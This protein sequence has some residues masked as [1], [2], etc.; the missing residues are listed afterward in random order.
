MRDTYKK[1]IDSIK[2]NSNTNIVV[3]CSTSDISYDLICDLCE[4]S[5]KLYYTVKFNYINQLKNYIATV[6]QNE[7]AQYALTISQQYVNAYHSQ[8][9]SQLF[10]QSILFLK[11]PGELIVLNDDEEPS[12]ND[13]IVWP[14]FNTESLFQK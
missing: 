7:S 8:L 9:I 11:Y 10:N 2:N 4:R 5:D 12:F 13:D 3:N 14:N 1:L 6:T